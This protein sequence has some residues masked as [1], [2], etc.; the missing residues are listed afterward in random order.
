MQH[1]PW[2]ISSFPWKET[3]MAAQAKAAAGTLSG[4]VRITGV[5]NDEE[6]SAE[7]EASGNPTTGEYRVTL[8]YKHIPR[9]W[10]PLMYT[11]VK[12]SLLFLKEE[13]SAVNFLTLCGG[14]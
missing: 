2:L 12:V 11:D 13:G 7:G 4:E 5:I 6:F 1:A 9:G 10:H 8:N 14:T 3:T